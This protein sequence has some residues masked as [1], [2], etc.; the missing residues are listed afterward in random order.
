VG[1]FVLRS[2]AGVGGSRGSDGFC[3]YRHLWKEKKNK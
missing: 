3:F 2:V 1:F